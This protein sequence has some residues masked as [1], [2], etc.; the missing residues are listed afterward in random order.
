[1]IL[2]IVNDYAKYK[3]DCICNKCYDRFSMEFPNI[4]PPEWSAILENKIHSC[5]K[6]T[7]LAQAWNL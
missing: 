6:C 4:I 3:Y 1:M 7:K 5:E 2:E